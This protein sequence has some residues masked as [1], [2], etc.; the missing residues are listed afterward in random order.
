MARGRVTPILVMLGDR[1]LAR[2]R[3]LAAV[4]VKSR[5]NCAAATERLRRYEL[6]YL[7]DADTQ[8]PRLSS[9]RMFGRQGTAE[10]NIAVPIASY[11]YGSATRYDTPTNTR[12]LR[13]EKT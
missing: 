9:V 4:D 3:T 6:S 13:Y 11:V 2:M 5:P 12:K 8:L 10:E 1:V 7:S